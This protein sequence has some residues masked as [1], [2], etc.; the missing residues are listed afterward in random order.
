LNIIHA[1]FLYYKFITLHCN[2]KLP[3]CQV[4]FRFSLGRVLLFSFAKE[5]SKQKE[6]KA[7]L[8]N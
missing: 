2:A 3:I 6:S 5:K 7:E 4:I 1:F 8:F